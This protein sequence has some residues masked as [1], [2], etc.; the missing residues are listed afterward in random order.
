MF[1]YNKFSGVRNFRIFTVK[2]TAVNSMSFAISSIR[3]INYANIR[4]K[5]LLCKLKMYKL[6]NQVPSK[7]TANLG[8]QGIVSTG[9][10]S[11]KFK[12]IL[13]LTGLQQLDHD[14]A[15]F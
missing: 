12:L 3:K 6:S 14:K 1:N 13:S 10:G 2:L 11:N 7:K 8:K 5:Y 15:V 9:L 4:N